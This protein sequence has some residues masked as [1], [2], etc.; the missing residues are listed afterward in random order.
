MTTF[1]GLFKA[2]V[3]AFVKFQRELSQR[4]RRD[5]SKRIG[6]TGPKGVPGRSLLNLIIRR[7][8]SAFSRTL[9]CDVTFGSARFMPDS[10]DDAIAAAIATSAT[11]VVL[12]QELPN[13]GGKVGVCHFG[14]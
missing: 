7:P 8:V 4:G 5:I 13:L 10:D 12:R 1:S 6:G 14:R 2:A 9:G 3:G 11:V